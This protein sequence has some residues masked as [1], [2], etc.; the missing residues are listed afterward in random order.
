MSRQNNAPKLIIAFAI[1]AVLTGA[2]TIFLVQ[3]LN[4]KVYEYSSEHG[5]QGK[6]FQDSLGRMTSPLMLIGLFLIGGGVVLGIVGSKTKSGSEPFDRDLI[7]LVSLLDD[8]KPRSAD[9]PQ[10][11]ESLHRL[12]ES[13]NRL[14]LEVIDARK[15]ERAVIE[16]AVDVICITDIE[17]RFVSV[18]KACQSA[19]GY[20]PQ[21]LEKRP[22]MEILVSDDANSILNSILGS[23]KSIDKIVFECKLRKKNGDLID[24]VWTGH[25]SASDGGLFCIVHDITERKRAEELVKRSEERLRRTLEGL[26]AGVLIV[27][28]AKQVEFA[29]SEAARM[30][31]RS[32][33]DLMS[34]QADSLLTEKHP[35][36]GQPEQLDSDALTRTL[37]TA[38]RADGN[39]FP[40]DLSESKIDLGGEQK[41]IVVFLD[42]TKEQELEQMKRE[43]IAMVTHDIRT[44]LASVHGILAL[45]EEGILGQLTDQGR[46][47][48]RRVK[49]TCNRLLRLIND[50]LDLEK[51][52]AGKF[53]LECK[54]ASIKQAIDNSVENLI[55]LADERKITFD[56]QASDFKCWA[57]EDR[58]VQVV[59]NLLSNA[60]KYSPD[61]A[62]IKV[63]TEDLGK[64][65]KVSVI[66]KGR[67]I[68]ADKIHKVF[69]QFEQV[70]ISDAKQKGGTGLGLSICQAI[71]NEHGGEI[72]VTSTFGAGSC[73]WF[74]LPKEA[75]IVN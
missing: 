73:F 60:I 61:D 28:S 63:V 66:D 30:L 8:G 27:N 51:I 35:L 64:S 71:V 44:P 19:W 59:V 24:V 3:Q 13:I 26:P 25:W 9:A 21:E 52:H 37:A 72:G 67:G 39:S 75:K 36:E 7:E 69:S 34:R 38:Q 62:S 6:R 70:D 58:I 4:S 50:L 18:S 10:S 54:E 42:K 17:S 74:T 20:S 45:L 23:A 1:A 43:F 53:T 49:A 31:H 41:E 33:K 29:N 11:K 32:S 57:D 48:T 56:V 46:A 14:N 5:T 55:A 68:P 12:R 2:A 40:V 15:R 47:T 22:L 65:I 16:R